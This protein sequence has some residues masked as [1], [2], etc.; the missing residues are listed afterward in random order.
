MVY[1]VRTVGGDLGGGAVRLAVTNSL[2]LSH[3]FLCSLLL[4]QAG[5]QAPAKTCTVSSLVNR[6]LHRS[7]MVCLSLSF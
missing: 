1:N 3:L 4:H 5:A 2:H 6:H 7:L